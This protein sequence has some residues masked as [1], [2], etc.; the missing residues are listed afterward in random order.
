M[1]ESR[2]ATARLPRY[3][4][5]VRVG[6]VQRPTI[7]RAFY[8]RDRAKRKPR[9]RKDDHGREVKRERESEE[10]DTENVRERQRQM[11]SA[12]FGQGPGQNAP[13]CGT[14]VSRADGGKRGG[15]QELT[16]ARTR[17]RRYVQS[18]LGTGGSY[19]RFLALRGGGGGNVGDG[20]T[21]R[22]VSGIRRD[23]CNLIMRARERSHVA[24]CRRER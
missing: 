2:G 7:G 20:D 9:I 6:L 24:S 16:L 13:T 23:L 10:R 11:D 15:R 19:I 22:S 5:R 8:S 4:R 14:Y 18:R 12:D 21:Y 3:P 1:A 17:K